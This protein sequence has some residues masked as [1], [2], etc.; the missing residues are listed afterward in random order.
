MNISLICIDTLYR[1]KR[2]SALDNGLIVNKSQIFKPPK[3][4]VFEIL[5]LWC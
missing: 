3:Q 1:D 4:K 2:I 5:E